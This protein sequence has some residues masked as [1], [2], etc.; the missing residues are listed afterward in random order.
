MNL[1]GV[2][3]RTTV[4]VSRRVIPMIFS[5]DF[6]S[7]LLNSALEH[8]SLSADIETAARSGMTLLEELLDVN[9][10]EHAEQIKTL[11]A[12]TVPLSISDNIYFPSWQISIAEDL[13][14]DI[15]LALLTHGDD[16]RA[17]GLNPLDQSKML[18]L[19]AVTGCVAS[20]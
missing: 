13:L 14:D 18:I 8:E 6:E 2:L 3:R 1:Q 7:L 17:L 5:R 19:L 11:I 9:E 4:P 10:L 16:L 15:D 20:R 12:K